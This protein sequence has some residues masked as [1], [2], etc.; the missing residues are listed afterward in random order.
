M[1][2]LCYF[3]KSSDYSD[4]AQVCQIVKQGV[5]LLMGGPSSLIASTKIDLKT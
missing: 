4:M 1:C 2:I 3:Y 5:H